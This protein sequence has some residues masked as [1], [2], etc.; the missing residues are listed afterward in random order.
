[1]RRVGIAALALTLAASLVG[2]A[3]PAEDEA[4]AVVALPARTTLSVRLTS[5][6]GSHVSRVPR[7]LP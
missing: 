5:R 2:A 7:R 4:D 1:M 6:A 3:Y